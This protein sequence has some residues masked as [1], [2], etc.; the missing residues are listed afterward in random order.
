MKQLKVDWDELDSAFHNQN[1]ELVYYLDLVTGHVLMEGEGEEEDL[2]DEDEIPSVT[3]PTA[4]RRDDRTRAYI[5]PP[6]IPL[7]LEW[8][9]KLLEEID[10][11]DA[12]ALDALKVTIEQD[13]PVDGINE[14]FREHPEVRDR[15]YSYRADRVHEMIVKWLADRSVKTSEPPP[16]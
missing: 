8:F 3:P 1:R 9:R 2:S 16:W 5:E 4:E 7:K 14:F 10:D 12:E 13:E 11:V 6:D 15:W